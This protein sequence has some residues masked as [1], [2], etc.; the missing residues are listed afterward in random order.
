MFYDFSSAISSDP[1]ISSAS[2]L[3][4]HSYVDSRIC[5]VCFCTSK[6]NGKCLICSQNKEYQASLAID[7]SSLRSTGSSTVTSNTVAHDAFS[8]DEP[9]LSPASIRRARLERFNDSTDEVVLV[10]NLEVHRLHLR[11]ELM[12]L[13]SDSSIMDFQELNF[14]VIDARGQKESGIGQGVTKDVM[15]TVFNELSNSHMI[16]FSEKVPSIR[17]DMSRT[18]WQAVAR[19]VLWGHKL[20]YW[21]LYLSQAFVIVTLFGEKFLTETTLLDSFK[22]YVSTDEKETL[23]SMLESFEENN[24]PLI[25][26]L[27][28][29][30]CF[31][32]PTKDTLKDIVLE[33]AH[34]ELIQKPKYVSNCFAEVANTLRTPLFKSVE[35]V[36]SLY[37][38]RIPTSRK[39][40][41]CLQPPEKMT[42]KQQVIIEFLKKII[43][44]LD[45][46]DL[47]RF[48]RFITG[49]DNIPS[50]KIAVVFTKQ[51]FRAPRSRVCISQLEL[52]ESY[53]QYSELAEEL[54]KILSCEDSFRFSIV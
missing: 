16:G 5:Q 18:A 42:E 8:H 45:N 49:S 19:M 32:L 37:K 35:D 39:V 34:Q 9:Q 29:Y 12:K 52:D 31:R 28:S 36:T 53:G 33:I 11:E 24:E 20:G 47:C 14:T 6:L 23:I 10:K 26:L 3:Y 30:K 43:K 15:C 38:G 21:P 51:V 7:S 46:K 48:L 41:K 2:V 13:F 25:D 44:S 27:S 40:V 17:H 4:D 1:V 22:Q 50:D 54:T